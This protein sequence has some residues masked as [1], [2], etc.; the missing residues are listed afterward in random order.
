MS[1]SVPV[2]PTR[3]KQVGIGTPYDQTH[4]IPYGSVKNKVFIFT[5]SHVEAWEGEYQGRRVL[6]KVHNHKPKITG[7]LEKI[8]SV[9][10][11]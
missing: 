1:K 7:D 5:D 9:R 4:F 3:D 11:S 2:T 10:H 8:K 6:V